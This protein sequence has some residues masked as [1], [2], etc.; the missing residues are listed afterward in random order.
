MHSVGVYLMF[1]W[2]YR[3]EG[4]GGFGLSFN[5]VTRGLPPNSVRLYSGFYRAAEVTP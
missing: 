5:M 1:N 4:L 3:V 2:V